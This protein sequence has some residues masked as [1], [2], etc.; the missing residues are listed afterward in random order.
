MDVILD[1]NIWLAWLVF[2]DPAT[3]GLAR[4]ASEGRLAL[5]VVPRMRAELARVLA[6]PRLRLEFAAQVDALVRFDR[7][8][9]M[10]PAPAP[11]PATLSCRDPDD[12]IFVDLALAC[13]ASWLLSR[14]RELLRLARPAAGRG[15][16]IAAPEHPAWHHALPAA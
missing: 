2:D 8:S 3:R 12:Q 13:E 6:Y 9:R 10:V 7:H 16:R 1:T 14:D 5:P 4:A 11:A 15:L